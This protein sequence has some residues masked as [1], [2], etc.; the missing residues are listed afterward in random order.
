MKLENKKRYMGLDLNVVRRIMFF[1]DE[2][3]FYCLE[4]VMAYGHMTYSDFVRGHKEY[5][6]PA[7][8]KKIIDKKVDTIFCDNSHVFFKGVAF[9]GSAVIDA[10]GTIW[11]DEDLKGW[12]L[13]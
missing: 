5:K 12:F 11:D 1:N 8:V 4:S 7:T 6:D 9:D 10:D 3:V 2:V 13:V